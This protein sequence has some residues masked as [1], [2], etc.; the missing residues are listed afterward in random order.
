MTDNSEDK[1]YGIGLEYIGGL[2]SKSDLDDYSNELNKVGIDFKSFDKGGIIYNKIEEYSLL[3]FLLLQDPLLKD[4]LIGC[5]SE[6]TM[7]AIKAFIKKAWEKVRGEKYNKITPGTIEEKMI[8][9]GIKAKLDYNTVFDFKFDGNL[10]E[11]QFDN[12]LDKILDF[13]KEQNR[14][15][16]YKLPYFVTYD[17][18][19]NTWNKIYVFEEIREKLKQKEK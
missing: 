8:S 17:K 12:A 5:I 4:I 3:V 9:F 6:A 19:K 1:K 13:L 14:N 7:E 11:K 10:T 15:D 18:E 16:E 2:Y